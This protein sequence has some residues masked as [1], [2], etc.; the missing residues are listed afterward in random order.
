MRT[1]IVHILLTLIW[2]GCEPVLEERPVRHFV[3]E[4]GE[5]YSSPRFTETL[6]SDRLVFEATFDETAK[7]TFEDLAHQ[8]SKN[9][10]LGFADCNSKH[11][12]N[13]AR[14]G[15][16][17]YNDQ[18]EIYAYCYVNAVRVERFVG[19][20][21]LHKTGR[22]EITIR[23]DEYVFR[24]DG[25]APVVVPR[26]NT[27]DTGVYYMLWPYFG[28]TLPAPHNVHVAISIIH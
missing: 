3:V 14:F 20:A 13:S 16:Q 25:G 24:L 12:D 10:L 22:Y 1:V 2:S 23:D 17:W 26:G 7:Y 27:C 6:Q 11:H 8:S 18:L 21:E 4:K 9:K 28:G 15:W 5:H 19:I